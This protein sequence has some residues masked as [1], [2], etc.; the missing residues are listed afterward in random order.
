MA[1]DLVNTAPSRPVPAALRRR[2][3]AGGGRR[4][5]ERRGAGRE[6]AGR[7]TATAASWASARARCTRRGWSGWSTPRRG[8]RGADGGLCRQGHHL[9]LR[10]PVAQAAQVDGDDES[11]TWAARPRCSGRCRPSP[12]C[13]RT[14]GSSAT[15]RWPRTC[16]A[17]RAQRPSDV[18][19]IYGGKTVE[20]LNTDAEGRLVLADA[21]A[22]S[23]ADSPRRARRRGHADR[24]PAGR[25]RAADRRR[26]GQRRRTA[27]RRG[28]RRGPAGEAMWPMPLPDELR[29]GLD[30]TVAD[31][32]NVAPATGSAGCWS[33]GCSCGNS[34]RTACAGRTWTSPGRVQRGRT[35][36]VYPQGRDRRRDPDARADRAWT[37]PTDRL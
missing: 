15:C 21:L 27:G 7:G 34:S 32:A 2:G 17:G 16:R 1:R 24:R 37:W 19:T 26:D 4:R 3:G 6:G 36:R 29:K 31:L 8:R 35:A 30:S 20:V 22:R 33:P 10:R 14:S 23:A 18:L 5:A 28:R 11:Q 12:R 25:A 9:R 13:G